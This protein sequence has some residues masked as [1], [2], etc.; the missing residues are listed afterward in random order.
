MSIQADHGQVRVRGAERGQIA[1]IPT[2]LEECIEESNPV[3]VVDAFIDELDLGALGFTGVVPA[4]MGRPPYHPAT[5]LKLSLYGYL[6]RVQSSRQLER[7]AKRNVEVMWLTRR[8]APDFKTIVNPY[9]P[10]PRTSNARAEGRFDKE[11]F[12]YLAENDAYRCPAGKNADVSLHEH[13]RRAE[14]AHLLHE[15]MWRLPAQV[16]LHHGQ[17]AACAAVGARARRRCDARATGRDA[18]RDDR[19]AAHCRTSLR[20]LEGMHGPHPLPNQGA[21]KGEHR[22][23]S[24]CLRLQCKAND[25]DPGGYAADRYNPD[26]RAWPRVPA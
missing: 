25:L 16:T 6:D 24:V 13:P 4:A 23:E 26:M 19:A 12:D 17:G 22:D 5:M 20:H 1:L 8:L 10:K 11:D 21:P 3:R 9:V 18:R 14:R 7:E 2:S 15:R